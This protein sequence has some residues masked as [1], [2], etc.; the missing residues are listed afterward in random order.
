MRQIAEQQGKEVL[1]ER[2]IVAR[3]TGPQETAE[4]RDADYTVDFTPV[5]TRPL[6]GWL[7]MPLAAAGAR[8]SVFADVTPAALTPVVP[9]NA[10]WVFYGVTIIDTT[11]AI[12]EMYFG[13][14]NGPVPKANFD[15]EKMYSKLE[16]DG[17]FSIPVVYVPQDI[18]TCTVMSR[19]VTG[20]GFR[21]ALKT[22]IVEPLQVTN[23]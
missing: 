4:A 10:C 5:A 13:V 18:V 19:I 12:K 9:N 21:V 14:G 11:Q 17:F 2:K 3:P 20:I 7:S 22:L 16:T 8:Y 6:T 23:A 15:L 1:Y